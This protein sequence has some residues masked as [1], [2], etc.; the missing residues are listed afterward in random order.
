M[1]VLIYSFHVGQFWNVPLSVSTTPSGKVF[2]DINSPGASNHRHIPARKYSM[3][4]DHQH[5]TCYYCG[6]SQGGPEASRN[7]NESVIEGL[8]TDYQ[9]GGLFD[10]QFKFKKFNDNVCGV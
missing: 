8:Y 7:Q 9:T 2:V 3:T 1:K 6:N 5:K 4:W 10:T